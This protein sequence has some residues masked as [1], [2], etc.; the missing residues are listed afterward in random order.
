[1]VTAWR[2]DGLLYDI[3]DESF[4]EDSD[5]HAV[6]SRNSVPVWMKSVDMAGPGSVFRATCP[7]PVFMPQLR[8]QWAKPA[9]RAASVSSR[10]A[11]DS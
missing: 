10:A 4:S 3:D 6:A 7:G 1:V 2:F 11:I 8:C 5:T 9:R